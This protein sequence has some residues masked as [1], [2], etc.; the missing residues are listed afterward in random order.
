[1]VRMM[2]IH[3]AGGSEIT[4]SDIANAVL[5]LAEQLAIS[6]TAARVDIPV[7]RP[8]DTVGRS[9][10]LLG[11]ASQMVAETVE[12]STEEILDD[13]LVGEIEQQANALRRQPVMH[14]DDEDT[15]KWDP[16]TDVGTTF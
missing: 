10:F 16:D 1:M 7:L 12:T 4:G 6:G 15:I 9:V 14:A 5:H 13:G 11:P 2:R 8:D 3:Y